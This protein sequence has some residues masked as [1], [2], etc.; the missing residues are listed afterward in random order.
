MTTPYVALALV[1]FGVA[2]I[3]IPPVVLVASL[4]SGRTP[5]MGDLKTAGVFMVVGVFAILFAGSGA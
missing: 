1:L 4:T 5:K 3:S 2:A